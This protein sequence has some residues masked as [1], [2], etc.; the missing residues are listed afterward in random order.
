MSHQTADRNQ[1]RGLIYKVTPKLKSQG[2][3]TKGAMNNPSS[4]TQG[5]VSQAGATPERF[6]PDADDAVGNRDARQA[7]SIDKRLVSN[8]GDQQAID[9]VWNG[10][11]SAGT[12][13]CGDGDLVVIV[14]IVTKIF[15]LRHGT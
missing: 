1:T 12:D 2:D 8:A 11:R 7:G 5:S 15:G 9:P 13:I 14:H 10:H 6:L 3:F 4:V